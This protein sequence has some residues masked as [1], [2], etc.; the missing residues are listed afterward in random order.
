MALSDDEQ[1]MLNLIAER[2]HQDDPKLATSLAS[3]N[4][5]DL[6]RKKLT[7]AVLIF[8][9]GIIVLVGAVPVGFLAIGPIGFL[10]ALTGGVLIY[11]VM[12]EG[13]QKF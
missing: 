11:R 12:F 1:R 13:K 6:N 10:I 2:M 7:V 5:A 8:L 4:R 9:F 3:S